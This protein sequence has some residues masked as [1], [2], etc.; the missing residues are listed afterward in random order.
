MSSSALRVALPVVQVR[1]TAKSGLSAVA[2]A[3][4]DSG[5]TNTFCTTSLLEKIKSGGRCTHL[6]LA[7]LQNQGKLETTVH[8][9]EV[10]DPQGHNQ[11]T[12]DHMYA[13]KRIPVSRDCSVQL[14]EL[15]RWQHLKGLE[16][17]GL[18]DDA[19]VEML[20][21]QDCPEVLVPLK[22]TAAED[23][24][25]APFA[26]KTL[27]GWTINGPIRE[28]HRG[29]TAVSSM[30]TCAVDTQSPADLE[31]Q[32]EKFWKVEGAQPSSTGR[33]LSAEDQKVLDIMKRSN[34]TEDGHYS[35]VLPFRQRK[36]LPNNRD[37]AEQR[38]IGLAKKLGKNPAL[39]EAY[40]DGM[41][42]LVE[43]GYAEKV[44]EDLAVEKGAEWYIPHHPVINMNKKICIVFD[45]AAR[46]SGVGLHDTVLQG[47]DLTNGL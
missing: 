47:P 21:G 38:L 18:P 3:L 33:G 40:I 41:K 10:T 17:T 27:Y 39:K 42:S 32:I 2:Y 7:T 6:S 44:P 5:L 13:M 8:E 25:S 28:A 46:H 36:S 14:K 4:L 24:E 30:M 35:V 15:E 16:V 43:K 29:T 9:L 19:D 22:V 34:V 1:I 26:T 23:H 45:C 11:V 20:I 12:L 37:V 31:L